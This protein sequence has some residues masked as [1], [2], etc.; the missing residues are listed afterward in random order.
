M[1]FLFKRNPKTPQE[2]I[3][4]LNDN[5][6]KLDGSHKA[7]EEVSRSLAGVRHLLVG[8]SPDNLAQLAQEVYATDT[9]L[10][11]IQKLHEIEFDSRK[12]VELL[13]TSLLRRKIGDR[14]PTVDYLIR[15]PEI[16]YALM[17][18]PETPEVS[19]VTTEMLHDA[20]QYEQLA[21]MV[22]TSPLF[23]KYFDYCQSR[24]FV[25]SMDAFSTLTEVLNAHKKATSEF[26]TQNT[27]EFISGINKLITSPSY[28]L[29]RESIK[30]LSQ[31]ILQRTNYA[32]LTAYV[33]DPH[34]LKLIMILL[35]DKSNNISLEAF[36][37]FKVF[38]ANPRKSKPIIDILVKNRDKLLQ[39]LPGLSSERKY[40]TTN[41]SDEKTFVI[42]E[43]EKLPK[44][45]S[46]ADATATTTPPEPSVYAHHT[47]TTEGPYLDPVLSAQNVYASTKQALA[48]N[49]RANQ[50]KREL[51][52][53]PAN[54][55]N[56]GTENQYNRYP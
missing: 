16:I 27:E 33:S 31:L 21:T 51:A 26:L 53:L 5:V 29:K 28:A 15:Q 4:A 8:T 10:P 32:L 39:F 36:N 35:G 38:V 49:D 56:N 9:L 48:S 23:W 43:I 12:T 41:L 1:A 45:V 30:L 55:N 54:G 3:R 40:A 46:A 47:A 13:F 20:L 19:L 18:G 42:G 44:I 6:S 34:N 50:V 7:Q 24:N 25:V 37:V 2:L 22:L 52:D 14:S 17:R 11:L